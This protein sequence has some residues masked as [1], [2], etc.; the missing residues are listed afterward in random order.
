MGTNYYA[1]I[2]PTQ[3][4]KQH[5]KELIDSDK[6]NDVREMI[7]EMYDTISPDYNGGFVGGRVHLGKRS[8]GWKFLWNPNCYVQENGHTEW[9]EYGNGARSGHFVVDGREMVYLYPLTQEGLKKF[10]YQDNIVIYDEY[11]ERQD[12][13]EFWKMTFRMNTTS[14]GEPAF[15]SYLYEQKYPNEYTWICDNNLI[16]MFEQEGYKFTSRTRSDFY[17]D[18]LR[19]STST[20]FL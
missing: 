12:K 20:D 11:G 19:F 14:D 16:R 15:D 4:K 8:G 1:H 10:I 17:S 13:D 18:G 2:L 6:F 7:G 5:L 3:E 9:V